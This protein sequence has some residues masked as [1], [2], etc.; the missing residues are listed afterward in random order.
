MYFRSWEVMMVHR[1]SGRTVP[2]PPRESCSPLGQALLDWM[3]EQK[4][5]VTPPVLAA[6]AGVERNTLMNWLTPRSQ[7]QPLQ[8]LALA[9]V[10]G[11][12][13][14]HI[15]RLAGVSAD[16]VTRQRNFLWDYLEWEMRRFQTLRDDSN[17]AMFIERVHEARVVA[18]AG[19]DAEI[20][21]DSDADGEGKSAASVE[22]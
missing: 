12:P 3:W 22:R 20:V 16:R 5:P 19:I 10:T 11:L 15:A 21:A 2:W 8:V 9:Q 4:P 17:F 18:D 1:E 6:R 13:L 14:L 7:P